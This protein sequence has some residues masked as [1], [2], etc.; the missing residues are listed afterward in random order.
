MDMDDVDLSKEE[1]SGKIPDHSILRCIGIGAYGRVWLA[2]NS[3][4]NFRAVK[5]IE[6]NRFKSTPEAFNLEWEGIKKYVEISTSHPRLVGIFHAGRTED[7]SYFYYVME[8]GDDVETGRNIRPD[9]YRVHTL[10]DH[11][12]S[13]GN[14]L[15]IQDC[16]QIGV[17][18]TGALEQFHL[19]GLL[20]RDVKPSNS[21]FING[22]TKLTDIGLVAKLDE[23]PDYLGTEGFVPTE[24]SNS[25]QADIFSLGKTLYE[26]AT[27]LDRKLFPNPPWS[28]KS[29]LDRQM[30]A[31]LNDVLVKACHPRSSVRYQSAREM[32]SELIAIENG[33][34][35]RRYRLQEQAI[36]KLTI[37]TKISFGVSMAL[38]AL[39]LLFFQKSL[40]QEAVANSYREF[41][42]ASIS[43]YLKDGQF[44]NTFKS[45]ED[46]FTSEQEL[47]KLTHQ[48]VQSFESSLIDGWIRDFPILEYFGAICSYPDGAFCQPD[49]HLN[50]SGSLVS[51]NNCILLAGNEHGLMVGDQGFAAVIK[52]LQNQS[53]P[54][55]LPGNLT[56]L[57]A[58]NTQTIRL[59][60]Q[61]PTTGDLIIGGG[62]WTCQVYDA[63]TL[64]RRTEF[65]PSESA[66]W[67][68]RSPF[69]AVPNGISFSPD[70][71][72]IAIC[73]DQMAVAVFE[74]GTYR[75][76]GSAAVLDFNY[77][78]CEGLVWSSSGRST[79][80]VGYFEN[81][82]QNIFIIPFV[83]GELGQSTCLST[84]SFTDLW[85]IQRNGDSNLLYLAGGDGL[86]RRMIYDEDAYLNGEP[87]LQCILEDNPIGQK[88]KEVRRL[89][90]HD[91]MDL[92]GSACWDNILRLNSSSLLPKIIP[93]LPHSGKINGVHFGPDATR[94]MTAPI[95]CGIWQPSHTSPA[96]R[97]IILMPHRARH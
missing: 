39:V 92:L 72:Y 79:V 36:K 95:M 64:K 73:Y 65:S 23:E 58:G 27:G 41:Q 20:H 4:G 51:L 19:N 91:A 47:N 16:I 74:V 94:I 67:N 96:T 71:K 14:R 77:Y 24:G 62:D 82:S 46:T 25:V 63:S 44:V 76:I 9:H 1:F 90:Y 80:G 48:N 22:V 87:I 3:F 84:A 52:L 17:Q 10:Q 78:S 13:A 59:A 56:V 86:I 83:D 34:S 60:A 61:C 15:S 29:Q 75:Q 26:A 66:S 88:G 57:Q 33:K 85:D 32:Q 50:V 7:D 89:F 53:A 2:V 81:P 97:Q 38:V 30:F 21:I 42:F 45:L 8:L 93:E 6:R 43:R 69:G 49:P 12:F 11:I 5:T 18:L 37:F 28:W 68:Q 70:G 55:K 31:E 40:Q 54:A 35:L